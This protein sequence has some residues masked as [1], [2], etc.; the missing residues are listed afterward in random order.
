MDNE[1]FASPW[2]ILPA[3]VRYDAQLPP[4][5]K[6][7]FAEIAAKTNTLGYCWAYNQY[8]SEKLGISADRVSD[9]IKRLEKSGYIVIDYAPDRTNTERRKIY[10][11]PAAF[12]FA[13]GGIGEN[14]ETPSRRKHRDGPGE[15]TEALKENKEK[16]NWPER[17][18]N[19]PLDIFKAIG[20]W[21]GEDGEL[22]LAWMQYAD[23]R[24]RTRHPIGT[25]ATVERAC[26]KIDTLSKGNRAY[27]LGLLHKATDSSWRGFF[28]LCRGDEGF[29]DP[30]TAPRVSEEEAGEWC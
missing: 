7:L 4:N 23:M 21:C 25:V 15:N 1:E 19:M 26:R 11:A 14:T 8:F 27:K 10:I 9:L 3:T 17:P 22:M 24:Q 20:A 18:K 2:A 13:V 16:E 5:A 12:C 6:L 29:D 28:P 30:P